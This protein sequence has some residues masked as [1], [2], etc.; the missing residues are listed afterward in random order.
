ML[1]FTDSRLAA[2]S[3]G[4]VALLCLGGLAV[5]ASRCVQ[6]AP[7]P[8][9]D[10]D[11]LSDAQEALFGTDPDD[12]DT[13]GD[14]LLDGEDPAPWRATRRTLTL[15]AGPVEDRGTFRAAPLT[16][17]L[18]A[19]DGAPL[20]GQAVVF[21]TDLGLLD[22]VVDHDDGTYT[23]TLRY[24]AGGRAT[25]SVRHED[26]TRGGVAV[27]ATTTV[28]FP[29]LFALP[30][31]GVNTG[32]FVNA[33]PLA[34]VLR[35]FTVVGDSA[36]LPDRAPVPYGGAFVQ[37]DLPEGGPLRAETDVNGL[38]ELVD[39]RLAQGPVTITVG[40]P[41]ARLVTL[42]DVDAATVCVPIEPLAPL[43][44]P[45]AAAEAFG[46]ITGH[47]RGFLGEGGLAPFPV[48]NNSLFGRINL[49][50]VQTGIRNRP[51]S[52]VSA[53]SV[54]EPVTVDDPDGG[55]ALVD[56]IPPNM[57]LFNPDAPE[58]AVFRLVDRRPGRHLV[59]ALAGE[60]ENVPASIQDLY[61]LRFEPRAMAFAWVD[62]RPGEE[63]TVDLTLDVDLT[64]PDALKIPVT[65]GSLPP[66]PVTGEALP[67]ALMMPVMDTG[68]GGF[69]FVDVNSAF[70]LPGF[71]NPAHVSF[72]NPDDPRLVA[73]GL[74]EEPLVVGLAGRASVGG[75]D[76]PG[77]STAVT[78][79]RRSVA[80][81]DYAAAAAW[82][83]L[84]VIDDPA[85]PPQGSPLD[86]VGGTLTGRRIAWHGDGGGQRPDL[87]VVRINAMMPAPVNPLLP[88]L[89]IGGP[90]SFVRWE[91][92]VPRTRCAGSGAAGLDE[93]EACEVVL[94]SLPADAGLPALA[95]P[96]PTD[97]AKA[98]GE[99][100]QGYAADVLEVEVNLYA[101]GSE[102]PFD[103]GAD[104]RF[105]DV[106][107]NASGVSQDS[108][109]F[110][111]PTE[112]NPG[113]RG[114]QP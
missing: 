13:D 48:E 103:Y 66:D 78:H 9:R 33:G 47:L 108:H 69:V 100:H 61:A 114:G 2:A 77:I 59:F 60:A 95:N 97:A 72:P 49:A 36:G 87:Y 113:A 34:G 83:H 55:A 10:G 7:G 57:I 15:S 110:R 28:D 4:V 20:P 91:V 70:N 8:D 99:A 39:P 3:S 111:V 21:S 22:P 63:T 14:G 37:V 46:S 106:N 79:R 31:P 41:G 96:A 109:V 18:L 76:P 32:D 112:S 5:G 43:G 56:F 23:T 74:D 68:G 6:A 105:A 54:L 1:A 67:N 24:G 101:L 16:A 38:A 82:P 11:G 73:L 80:P 89:T 104:F 51:L 64:S 30:Q 107:L 86:A 40:A 26:P 62:V 65:L 84:P 17:T 12:P 92:Y 85:P 90:R 71:E 35:I 42:V 94:P 50:I 19:P 58:E 29:S 75:A 102:R 81:V 93:P 27:R 44:D 52:S 98:A 88:E 45:Q 25:V 53:G